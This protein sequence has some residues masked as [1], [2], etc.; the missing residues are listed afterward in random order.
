ML[1]NS[2]E[3][4]YDH[5]PCTFSIH[6]HEMVTEH[7]QIGDEKSESHVCESGR[8]SS[9]RYYVGVC[10]WSLHCRSR[11]MRSWNVVEGSAGKSW[12]VGSEGGDVSV[13]DDTAA[14]S[15]A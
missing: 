2:N 14:D 11:V 5:L 9:S 7:A 4:V 10:P 3:H 1:D 6:V 12:A 13:V 15:V 8:L